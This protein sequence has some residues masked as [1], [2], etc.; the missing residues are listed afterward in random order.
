MYMIVSRRIDPRT[1][2]KAEGL[3][4]GISQNTAI[5]E[6]SGIPNA[7]SSMKENER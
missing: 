7:P 6:S 2:E 4:S 3:F 1:E 5:R